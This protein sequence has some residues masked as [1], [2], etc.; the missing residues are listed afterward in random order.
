[1]TPAQA[2]QMLDQLASQIPLP[3]AD[4][5]QVQDA[6]KILSRAIAPPQDERI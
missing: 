3:R 2:L 1:M 5:A 6:V 4:H